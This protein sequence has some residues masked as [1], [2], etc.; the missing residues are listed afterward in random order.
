MLGKCLVKDVSC[1]SFPLDQVA[2]D[3]GTSNRTLARLPY[4]ESD[5]MTWKLITEKNNHNRGQ[6]E[7]GS[8]S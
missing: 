3:T 5:N 1:T 4:G 6:I 7:K 2:Y 8:K